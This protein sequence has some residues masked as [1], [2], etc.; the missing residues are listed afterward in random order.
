MS[1]KIESAV[2]IREEM[3]GEECK[4][5]DQTN[6]GLDTFASTKTAPKIDD[7]FLARK[8]VRLCGMF[9]NGKQR[10]MQEVSSQHAFDFLAFAKLI[11]KKR[12]L[13]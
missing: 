13:F 1:G 11:F 3:S 7:L 6:V 2:K 5:D 9:V 8:T 12:F 4:C 10:R